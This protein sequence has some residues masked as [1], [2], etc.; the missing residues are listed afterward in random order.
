VKGQ[1]AEYQHYLVSLQ[2]NSSQKKIIY[3]KINQRQAHP[4]PQASNFELY[5]TFQSSAGKTPIQSQLPQQPLSGSFN[6]HRFQ[7]GTRL[8]GGLTPHIASGP[9]ES[10]EQ[11]NNTDGKIQSKQASNRRGE[12]LREMSNSKMRIM[13]SP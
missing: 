5:Q 3:P 1:N 8:N 2:K 10:V 7:T 12:A 11:L 4:D 9:S 13:E 6:Q